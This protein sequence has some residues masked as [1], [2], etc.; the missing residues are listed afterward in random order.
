VRTVDAI[1]DIIVGIGPKVVIGIGP[2]NII[3]QVVIGVG[4]EQRSEPAEH[5]PAT[6]PRPGRTEERAVESRLPELRLQRDVGDGAVAEYRGPGAPHAAGAPP[7]GGGGGG[8]D[9][10]ARA[11]EPRRRDAGTLRTATSD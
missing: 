4:P 3:E 9:P 8:G 1:V 10:M 5:E 7:Q 6:P 11:A 2:V